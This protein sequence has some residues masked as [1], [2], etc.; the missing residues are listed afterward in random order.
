MKKLCFLLLSI[1]TISLAQT[2][3]YGYVPRKVE[4][5]Q[6]N[7]AKVGKDLNNAINNALERREEQ[8]RALGWSSAAEMDAARKE[9]KRRIKREK[10]LE[11]ERK[12]AIKEREK[13]KEREEKEREEKE[14]E[15]E[16]EQN[17]N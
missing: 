1:P 10:A 16:K 17:I 6:V 4:T 12:K 5:S 14:R 13:E 15:K 11:K 9:E 8:A 7:Y 3:G 2:S